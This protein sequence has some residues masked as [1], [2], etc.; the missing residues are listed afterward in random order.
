MYNWIWPLVG[1]APLTDDEN[2]EM[3]DRDD[4][5]YTETLVREAI[6]NSLDA[7]TGN[8]SPATITFRFHSGSVSEVQSILS[9]AVDFRREAELGVPNDWNEGKFHW[10]T[11]EDFNTTGLDGRL[12][13]RFGNFWNYWLNFGMSNKGAGSRGGRGIGRVTFLIASRLQTVIG[14][15]RRT[16]DQK[17]AACAMVRLRGMKS[18]RGILATHAYLAAKEQSDVY[19]LHDSDEFLQE[20]AS[21][22]RFQGYRAQ[23]NSGGLALAIPYPH[24]DL[25]PEGIMA[26]A[27]EHFAPAIFGG[28]LVVRVNDL[29]IDSSK[30]SDVASNYSDQFRTPAINEDP[31]RYLELTAKANDDDFETVLLSTLSEWTSAICDEAIVKKLQSSISNNRTAKFRVLFPLKMVDEAKTVELKI[32]AAKTPPNKKSFDRFFREGMSLPDVKAR[33]PGEIDLFIFV[34]DQ[35]LANYLNCCEGKA[36]LNLSESK[37]IK[38]NLEK[39]GFSGSYEVKRFVKSLP[40]EIRM[41]LV[42]QISEP[43]NDIFEQFF[44]VEDAKRRNKP[45]CT[46]DLPKPD[47]LPPP[48]QPPFNLTTLETGFRLTANPMYKDYP[49]NLRVQMFYANG[50]RNPS[51]SPWD[52]RAD[53]LEINAQGCKIRKRRN[54][55]IAENCSKD[56]RIETTGFDPKREL[57][58]RITRVKVI[59]DA[60]NS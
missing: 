57:D 26:S 15:T 60:T 31:S 3:F 30:I 6:Q 14:Y 13:D 52:F 24:A 55:L 36:H 16:T 25:T 12:D 2:S 29:V 58:T 41:L 20:L 54:E 19:E 21:S 49:M 8:N 59:R 53:Q 11:I 34:E 32:V 18:D 27:I 43:S 17:I 39:S 40:S 4:F 22:F 48:R 45:P 28:L 37:E 51:W 23:N 38:R 5:P 9:Q 10:V 35:T 46:P 47:D 56:F 33:N 7:R 42:P 44:S 1:P 50:S